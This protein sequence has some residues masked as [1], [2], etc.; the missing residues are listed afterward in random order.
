MAFTETVPINVLSQIASPEVFK[1]RRCI[2][3]S[4]MAASG[5]LGN[6]VRLIAQE[7][8]VIET[9]VTHVFHLIWGQ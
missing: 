5:Y 7:L 4:K 6:H 2:L 1:D 9:I 3:N 8:F